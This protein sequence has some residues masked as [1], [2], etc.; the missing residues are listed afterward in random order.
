[1]LALAHKNGH[2]KAAELLEI[3]FDT[4]VRAI[5]QCGVNRATL[6]HIRAKLAEVAT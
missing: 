4:L 1:M 2:L 6:T 5:A 3:S